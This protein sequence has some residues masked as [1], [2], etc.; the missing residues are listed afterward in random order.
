MPQEKRPSSSSGHEMLQARATALHNLFALCAFGIGLF[1]IEQLGHE[2]WDDL[3]AYICLAFNCLEQLSRFGHGI[4]PVI[5]SRQFQLTQTLA[6]LTY[7]ARV[8]R[9]QASESQLQRHYI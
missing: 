9:D 1:G 5:D 7:K 2:A 3:H 8:N 6:D 4:A